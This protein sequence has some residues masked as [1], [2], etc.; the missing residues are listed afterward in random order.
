[1]IHEFIEEETAAAV[2]KWTTTEIVRQVRFYIPKV[3]TWK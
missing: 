2:P 1:M 3:F